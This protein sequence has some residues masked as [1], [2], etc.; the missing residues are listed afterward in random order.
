MI[1]KASQSFQEDQEAP[2]LSIDYDSLTNPN[3]SN[4]ANI[5]VKNYGGTHQDNGVSKLIPDAQY[6]DEEIIHIS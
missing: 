1:P 5:S 6:T 2:L 4:T 3:N